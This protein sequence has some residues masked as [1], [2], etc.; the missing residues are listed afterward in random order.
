M[1]RTTHLFALLVLVA[2]CRHQGPPGPNATPSRS[3]YPGDLA[4]ARPLTRAERSQFTETSHYDDVVR[5]VDSLRVLGGDV[6]T[7]SI[8]KT[9][10]GREIPYVIASR[11]LVRTPIEA[12]RLGR[13]IVYVQGNIHAGEVEGKEALQSLLR[14]LVFDRRPNVLDSIVLIAVPIYNAD[15]NERF[16]PQETNRGAQNGPQLVGIRANAQRLDLNRDYTKVEAPET[17][18]SLAMFRAWEPDVF[19]DL[20]TTDGSYHGYALTYAPPLNPAARFTGPYTRDTLLVE[21]RSRM[22]VR[23]GFEV[24]DYGDYPRDTT[25]WRWETYDSKPRYGTNYYGLRGRISVL[26]EAYSHDPF[27]R[28]VAA[29]YDF[30]TELLSLIAEN[31][32]DVVTGSKEA[33]ARTT[34]WG[35]DPGT[36]PMIPIRSVMTTTRTEPVL[37]QEM[38]RVGDSVRYEAGLPRG[39]RRTGR[40]REVTMPIYD[41]FS[42]T[43]S[44]KMPI[45]YAFT[46]PAA[47]SLLPRLAKHGVIVEQLEQDASLTTQGF[48]VDSSV[49]SPTPFQGHNERRLYGTW[50]P[51]TVRSFPAGTYVVRSGQPL[52][53]LATYLLEPESDDGFATWNVLDAFTE[54]GREYPVVRIVQPVQ[55]RLRPPSHED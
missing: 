20:H 10:E 36:A 49:A 44:V 32:D 9:N 33:D 8:G 31:A 15:G 43:T 22:R 19:V 48:I 47:D 5:F 13:P 14:D 23:H 55:V 7:G 11:P 52:G 39:L 24:F 54:R 30:V 3:R 27:A 1:H 16:G 17:N 38:Q 42:P 37:V 34:G 21:L 29:T 28:R 51:N 26:S 2:A 35:N 12:R 18:A 53:I 25:N 40:I 50:S 45:G 4:R 6:A 41:R 46:R